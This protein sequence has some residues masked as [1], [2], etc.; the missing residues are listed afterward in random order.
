[1]A[2][3]AFVIVFVCCG[4]FQTALFAL[5]WLHLNLYDRF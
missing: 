5:S 3:P 4:T 2:C 1:M